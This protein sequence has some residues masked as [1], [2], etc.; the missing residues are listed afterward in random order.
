MRV[1]RMSGEADPRRPPLTLSRKD[2]GSAAVRS[3]PLPMGEGS[4]DVDRHVTSRTLAAALVCAGGGDR[5]PR[6]DRLQRVL[7]RLRAGEAFTAVLCGARIESDGDAALITREAGEF[8]RRPR[9]P[10][11]LPPGV[12]TVW[13]GRWVMTVAEPGWS[14]VPAAGRMARLSKADR[15]R[16]DALPPAARAAWPVLFRNAPGAAVLAREGQ[17]A[18]S[19]VETRLALALDT[20]PHEGALV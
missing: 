13:D 8:R 4:F 19:L 6:G 11:P 9:P 10:L 17:G 2:D 12:E 15:A 5:P 18:A 16:L 7:D 1:D 3:S 20:T 14:V